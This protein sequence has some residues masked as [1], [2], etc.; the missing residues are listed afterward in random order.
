M[1][2][3]CLL[4]GS[5]AVEDQGVLDLWEWNPALTLPQLDSRD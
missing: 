3:G 1:V 5:Q 4:F 2:R